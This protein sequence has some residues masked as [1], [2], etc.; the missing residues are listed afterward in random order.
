VGGGVWA[1]TQQ[2]LDASQAAATRSRDAAM[3]RQ[4]VA[5]VSFALGAVED[6]P[7]SPVLRSDLSRAVTRLDQH[8]QEM[9]A[10]TS[11]MPADV[12][13]LLEGTHGLGVQ[14][15]LFITG[16]TKVSV[17]D[18]TGSLAVLSGD[19]GRYENVAADI[20]GRLGQITKSY[21]VRADSKVSES[22]GVSHIAYASAIVFLV[23]LIAAL[24]RPL[25][26]QLRDEHQALVDAGLAHR[27]EGARQELAA[28]LSEGLDAVETEPETM[29]LVSRAFG[30]VVTDTP[31]E[32][33]MSD[34][35]RTSLKQTATHPTAGA[36]GC[37]VGSPSECP[38]ITRGRTL[39]Y[40]N[41]NAIN[42]CPQ[43][44]GHCESGCSAVCVPLSFM[45]KSMGVVHA[46]GPAGSA[47]GGDI[48]EA[49]TMIATHAAVR[50]G[51]IRSFTQIEMQASTDML[52][53]LPNRRAT[54]DRLERL[55]AGRETGSVVMADLDH[56][57]SLNDTYGH[58]AGDRALRM[59][60]DSVTESLREED[61]VG[62][63]GGEEFVIV[64]PGLLASQAKTILD[65]VRKHLA[66]SC[67]RAE[68]PTVRV[69]MGVVDTESGD[70]ADELVRLAD[71]ALLAA[72]TQ[73]R[74]RVLIGP[75]MAAMSAGEAAD[76]E[77]V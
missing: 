41:S 57:K 49:L 34:M 53:G 54:E 8:W 51:T 29:M 36:P 16:T 4:D 40:D 71:E 6:S 60:A 5:S 15:K 62:R 11:N 30:R 72:K 52:T 64:M 45:G 12:S 13:L 23:L 20:S 50:V 61:W 70:D 38:A 19:A 66:D 2:G 48:K 58:E 39:V 75:V 65:R 63:W 9:L 32:L 55:I 25:E 22:R 10:D 59:F 56:F 33:L 46:T 67:V 24:L 35:S 17:A 27:K 77:Q 37:G 68:A 18:T 7:D 76:S 28:N 44:L 42:A 31:V 43:L 69:S 3:A 1:S 26:R 74:D 47:I 14:M 21:Q 73:G